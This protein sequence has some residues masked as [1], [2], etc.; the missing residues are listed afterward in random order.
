MAASRVNDSSLNISWGTAESAN[1]NITHYLVWVNSTSDSHRREVAISLPRS[2]IVTGLSE[3][4]CV[5]SISGRVYTHPN[6][7]GK[8]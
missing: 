6:S 5:V 8:T 7:S 1:G 2:L 3:S 4:L